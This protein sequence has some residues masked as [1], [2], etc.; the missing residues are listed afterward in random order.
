[1]KKLCIH[2]L[3]LKDKGQTQ[4]YI[5][6]SD[7]QAEELFQE[8]LQQCS[9][10]Q[11]R[12]LKYV[13]RNS[14]VDVADLAETYD[15]AAINDLHSRR[16]LIRSGS[17]YS[18][19]WDIFRDY[20]LTGKVPEIPNS[21]IPQMSVNVVYK[22]YRDLLRNRE[23]TVHAVMGNYGYSEGTA[24]NII[25]DLVSLGLATRLSSGTVRISEGV[26]SVAPDTLGEIAKG[27]REGFRDN[28]F[29]L[30]LRERFSIGEAISPKDL[31]AMFDSC[32]STRS[33][34]PQV[35]RS[36][37]ERLI[38]W[39]LFGGR[40][41]QLSD[42]SYARCG[43]AGRQAGRLSFLRVNEEG[44]RVSTGG[45]FLG[46]SGP[47]RAIGVLEG[48]VRG[49]RF[50]ESD[51]RRT[52]D[53]NAIQDLLGLGLAK[54]E[55]GVLL[56]TPFSGEPRLEVLTRA[57]GTSLV[58]TAVKVMEGALSMKEAREEFGE[59]FR[60]G[61]ARASVVRYFGAART[62]AKA[63]SAELHESS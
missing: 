63:I 14:P 21:F 24:T 54:W 37:R 42:G 44:K 60:P 10:E 48:L 26:S 13:A 53:R 27:I 39:L 41:E 46:A 7:L 47:E 59:V 49:A 22:V 40:I 6:A 31:Y 2:V 36:Y 30:A 58:R 28:A 29:L 8:D 35:G 11:I 43:E 19:Y 55:G 3:A 34:S 18:V 45:E 33:F 51:F 9:D 32:Y 62:W 16:L 15:Q 17:R 57:A 1:M 20:L 38:R 50:Q 61:A 56:P 12:C 5:V 4:D 23:L 52:K 25:G